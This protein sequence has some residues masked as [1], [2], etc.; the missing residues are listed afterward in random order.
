MYDDLDAKLSDNPFGGLAKALAPGMFNSM[1]PM[2][3]TTIAGKGAAHLLCCRP[4]A[5]TMSI[6]QPA[7]KNTHGAKPLAGE[8]GNDKRS[9]RDETMVRRMRTEAKNSHNQRRRNALAHGRC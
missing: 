9:H 1:K 8:R 4:S 6:S 3:V 2:F 7:W 5:H